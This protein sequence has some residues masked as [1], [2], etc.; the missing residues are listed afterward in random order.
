MKIHVHIRKFLKRLPI[1]P[2]LWAMLIDA[3]DLFSSPTQVVPVVGEGPK[4]TVDVIQ[5]LI[6]VA[7]FDNPTLWFIGV[8]AD[9]ITPSTLNIFVPSYT[10]AYIAVS[11]GADVVSLPQKIRKYIFI[12]ALIILAG[13]IAIALLGGFVGG[14]LLGVI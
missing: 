11:R 12:A 8:G 2:V 13:L 10:L 1:P 4:L 6:S 3:I 9:A 14:K 7:V 5:G